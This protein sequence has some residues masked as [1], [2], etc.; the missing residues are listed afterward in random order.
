MSAT[1]FD[2][3]IV[4]GGAAGLAA[5]IFTRRLNPRRSVAVLDG[6]KKLGAKILVSGGG[7]CNVTNAVVTERD[8]W[9]GR[10]TI[11]R[12]ILRAFGVPETVA[13]FREIGV[14]LHEEQDGKLFPD[15]NRARDVVDALLRE[16]ERVGV[17][18]LTDHRVQGV[19]PSNGVFTLITPRGSIAA[20]R[21]VLATGGCSLPKSGSDGIGYDIS[22]LLGHTLVP[23]T[24]A[25]APFI[26]DDG[27]LHRELSGVSHDAE[28]TVWIDGRRSIRLRGALLWTHFGIS[29]PLALN[30]SRHWHRAMLEHG[31]VDVRLHVLPQARFEEVETWL[32]GALQER[33]RARV[34]TVLSVRLP[35]AVAD[36]WVRLAGLA[37]DTT[38]AHLSREARRTLVHML[39]DV[40]LMVVDSRGYA[41]A[42]VTAGGVPLD[43]ID[44][45]SMASRRC[46]SLYLVGEILDV[47]GR[48]GGFNFQWAWSSAWVAGQA[49]G[50]A[51]GSVRRQ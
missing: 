7:R 40:P 48:L 43:E 49:I 27:G 1:D 16:A 19:Q 4:G 12:N 2:I 33:P 45:A 51:L 13:F 50:Q 11:V 10:S 37:D 32:Q 15:S 9:G 5:G 31:R 21:F 30:A 23:T 24:P 20:A 26:L 46:P 22:Q 47:D 34:G 44:A 36:A 3:A 6:A 14:P 8:F 25:L 38:L 17:T 39:T 41:F 29:G 18:V 28:L 42:E 35:A